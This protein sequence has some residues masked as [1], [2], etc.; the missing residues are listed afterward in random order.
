MLFSELPGV[1]LGVR[2]DLAVIDELLELDN[3]FI[4]DAGCGAMALSREL[5]SRGAR[6]LAIDPDTAQAELNR[7][8]ETI[9]NVGFVETGADNIPVE[10]ASVDGVIFSYSLHH[11]PESRYPAVFE[12]IRRILKPDGFVFVIEP[13]ADGSLNEVM[14]LFH[15]EEKVREAAQ[16]ALATFAIPYFDSCFQYR[17]RYQKHYSN[18]Q[19]FADRYA[20]RSYNSGSYTEA[21]V[22]ADDVRE[23]FERL[24]EAQARQD[25][26]EFDQPMHATLLKSPIRAPA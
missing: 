3:R 25:N 15:D 1:D 19:D 21:D 14:R 7:Q 8:A 11:V 9:P 20:T 12:E 4:V 22:R 16:Q 24:A 26:Y 10:N 17:Y 18:W 2:T 5:A 13:V 6:V 23:A